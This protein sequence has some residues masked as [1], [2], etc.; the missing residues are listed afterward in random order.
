MNSP[1]LIGLLVGAIVLLVGAIVVLARI[2]YKE[3]K[4]E[5]KTIEKLNGHYATSKEVADVHDRLSNY[6][7]AQNEHCR[8]QFASCVEQRTGVFKEIAA[9]GEKF[10]AIMVRLETIEK[11]VRNG[12]GKH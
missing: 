6:I 12:N 3:P 11:L 7:G 4:K 8:I 9:H 10:N 1:E 5:Q 2:I